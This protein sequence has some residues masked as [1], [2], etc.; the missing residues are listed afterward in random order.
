M[1][2]N[3]SESGLTQKE[4]PVNINDSI[5]ND[6]CLRLQGFNRKQ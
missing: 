5:K 1:R 4:T 3:I 6:L 2:D